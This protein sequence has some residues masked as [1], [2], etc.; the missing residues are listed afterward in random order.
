[1]HAN[2]IALERLDE[3][4]RDAV[5]FRAL[6]GSETGH[7]IDRQCE[8]AGV[9][10]RIDAAIVSQPFERVRRRNGPRSCGCLRA[11]IGKARLAAWRAVRA[12]QALQRPSGPYVTAGYIRRSRLVE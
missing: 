1:V 8:V 5:R 12:A 4:L 7:E 10:G 9:L 2:I 11:E 6:N 3:A